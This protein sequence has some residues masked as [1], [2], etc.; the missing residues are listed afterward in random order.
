MQFLIWSIFFF[1]EQAATMN[2][3]MTI[4]AVTVTVTVTMSMAMTLAVAMAMAMTVKSQN[5]VE[6]EKTH[7]R[8][9]KTN[10]VAAAPYADSEVE[11]KSPLKPQT[12]LQ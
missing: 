2:T 6:L 5:P 10:T 12:K 7:L 8:A 1:V 3:V 11:E 4:T 9:E